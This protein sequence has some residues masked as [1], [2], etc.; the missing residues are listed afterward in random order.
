MVS[1]KLIGINCC[2]IV[3]IVY[4]LTGCS[5]S[6]EAYSTAQVQSSVAMSK[7]RIII[8]REV[9]SAILTQFDQEIAGAGKAQME[10]A[11][12]VKFEYVDMDGQFHTNTVYHPP[13]DPS[14]AI[15]MK[16]AAKSM[17]I[18]EMVPLVGKLVDDMSINLQKPVTVEDVLYKIAGDGVILATMGTMYGLTSKLI[19]NV[20]SNVI[21]NSEQGGNISLDSNG[22]SG[23][24][25]PD[26][27][28]TTSSVS[29]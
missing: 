12:L 28:T 11:P 17:V 13:A 6:Y 22:G 27:S 26:N 16:G 10:Q 24:Y 25:R 4:M 20:R 5:A 7:G 15:F 9:V 18:R 3:I 19:D 1:K 23:S 21:A 2:L 29:E 14:I 8:A